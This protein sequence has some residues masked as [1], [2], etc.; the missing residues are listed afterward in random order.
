[1]PFSNLI[2][3]EWV[4]GTR[5]S[6]NHN[7][8]DIADVIGEYAQADAAQLDLAVEAALAAFPAWSTGNVQA[9]SEALDRIGTEI[10][11]RRDELGA[12]LAQEE[13]KTRP[14]AIGEVTR[15]GHIFKFFAGECLRL[16]GET[17]PSVRPAWAWRSRASRS[18]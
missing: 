3:G 9:R 14:E 4:V 13:G 16:T 18:A 8:S 15:A 6:P 12:L 7:P 5:V 2:A 10:L 11:A 17:V 1:M